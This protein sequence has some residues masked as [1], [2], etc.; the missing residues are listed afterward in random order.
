M[1]FLLF[2]FYSFK[3]NTRYMQ[4]NKQYKNRS[5]NLELN[6]SHMNNHIRINMCLTVLHMQLIFNNIQCHIYDAPDK[7][8]PTWNNEWLNRTQ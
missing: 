7:R 8:V 5:H 3:Q 1:A 4:G 2:F 6:N